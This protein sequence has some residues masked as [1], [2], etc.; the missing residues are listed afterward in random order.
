VLE[1]GELRITSNT[2]KTNYENT[3]YLV[4][5]AATLVLAPG[6]TYNST[7]DASQS[8]SVRMGPASTQAPIAGIYSRELNKKLY[9]IKDHLSNVRAVVTDQREAGSAVAGIPQ[10]YKPELAAYYNYYPF[11]MHQPSRTWTNGINYRYGFNGKERDDSG[12]FGNTNYDYG[13]RIYN[14]GL[15]RF[16]SEDPLSNEFA[17]W[18]PYQFAGNMPISA[19]DID[20]LEPGGTV[21]PAVRQAPMV[22]PATSRALAEQAA[23]QAARNGGSRGTY[24]K[25]PVVYSGPQ[26]MQD[27]WGNRIYLAPKVFRIVPNPL[28]PAVSEEVYNETVPQTIGIPGQ[29]QTFRS[30]DDYI[31]EHTFQR[32]A[33]SLNDPNQ[34]DDPSVKLLKSKSKEEQNVVYFYRAMSNEEY[35]ATKG[36]LQDRNSS[37]EGPHVRKDVTYL[38]NAKFIEKG[39]YDLIVKYRIPVA[40]A[41]AFDLTPYT[42]VP[43]TG[44]GGP[45][46]DAAR[47]ANWWYKKLEKG[48]SYG[49]PGASTA[50]FNESIIGAPEV[51]QK[52]K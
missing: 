47:G 36:Y 17:W 42:Y 49:F 35:A 26:Y 39:P 37:G 15:G 12:E 24:G 14:P 43:G 13:F 33:L 1:D 16:L 18:T 40:K 9:E 21:A 10:S 29:V 30:Y 19:V 22:S 5:G 3:S 34:A 25:V 8:F 31:K 11:G 28:G 6:F 38:L 51:V 44:P 20:G 7:S 27:Q 48:V 41:Q 2:T 52:I 32:V 46:F 23:G 45:T 4:N 50:A